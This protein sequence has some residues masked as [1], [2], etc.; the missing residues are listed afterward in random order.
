[1]E[2]HNKMQNIRIHKGFWKRSQ[3]AQDTESVYV[4]GD[5]VHD[6]VFFYVPRSTQACIRQ[7]HNV[8]GIP[9]KRSRWTNDEDYFND[10]DLKSFSFLLDFA[11]KE[12]K[13]KMEEGKTIVFPEN[14]IGT[15]KALMAEKAPSLFKHLCE[16]LKTEFDYDNGQVPQ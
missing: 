1:M 11:I 12:I 15:G 14:G 2:N 10:S 3:V 13:Q 6:S 8:I 9:T 5:N 4:F 16:R 7:L